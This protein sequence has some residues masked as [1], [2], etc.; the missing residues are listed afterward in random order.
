MWVLLSVMRA[1]EPCRE[2][3]VWC[4]VDGP[5]ANHELARSSWHDRMI[6]LA[7]YCF[8]LRFARLRVSVSPARPLAHPPRSHDSHLWG[9]AC[10]MP[11]HWPPTPRDLGVV[12]SFLVRGNRGVHSAYREAAA[13]RRRRRRTAHRD[14]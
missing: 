11:L 3:A 10:C 6:L 13:A 4:R 12:P 8:V 2:P 1:S 9:T 14:T 7:C 5:T